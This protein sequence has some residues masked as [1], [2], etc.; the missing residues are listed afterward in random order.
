MRYRFEGVRVLDARAFRHSDLSPRE[1]LG[2]ARAELARLERWRVENTH[3]Q[4]WPASDEP[5]M[6][7]IEAL[8]KKVAALDFWVNDSAAKQRVTTLADLNRKNET[9]WAGR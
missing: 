4:R 3:W 8:K 9:F 6:K 7:R 2:E 5:N 1:E